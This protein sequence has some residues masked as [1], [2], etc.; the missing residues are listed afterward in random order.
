MCIVAVVF[1][2]WF[3]LRVNGRRRCPVACVFFTDYGFIKTVSLPT[4]LANIPTRKSGNALATRTPREAGLYIK[5]IA[6]GFT[7][8]YRL[9]LNV[10]IVYNMP[11]PILEWQTP[12]SQTKYAYIYPQRRSIYNRSLAI[13][14]VFRSNKERYWWHKG[15]SGLRVKQGV[16]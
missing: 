5:R 9:M 3:L 11:R 12:N 6:P 15:R 1:G 13:Y 14:Y 2:V 4:P 10:N 16:K 7:T 8:K